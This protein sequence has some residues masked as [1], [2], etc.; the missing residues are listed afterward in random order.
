MDERVKFLV[1]FFQV[2]YLYSIF[3]LFNVINTIKGLSRL[4]RLAR[5]IKA[6]SGRLSCIMLCPEAE[7]VSVMRGGGVSTPIRPSDVAGSSLLALPCIC[8]FV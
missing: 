2:R 4:A 6:V 5:G 1:F 7:A 3:L 8:S